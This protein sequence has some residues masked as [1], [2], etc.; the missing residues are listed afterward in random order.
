MGYFVLGIAAFILG[1]MVGALLICR[2]EETVLDG[3]LASCEDCRKRLDEM[4]KEDEVFVES[5]WPKQNPHIT[6][7][8]NLADYLK[9]K[10]LNNEGEFEPDCEDESDNL[11]V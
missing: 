11:Y 5:V 1:M 2:W 10:Y 8:S 7:E 6:M 4:I 3:L 9:M